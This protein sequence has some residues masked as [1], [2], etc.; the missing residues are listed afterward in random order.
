MKLPSEITFIENEEG[1][2][3]WRC[4][5]GHRHQP[6]AH[7]SGQAAPPE[8]GRYRAV[9]HVAELHWPLSWFIS[10]HEEPAMM[11]GLIYGMYDKTFFP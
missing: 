2:W 11:I 9:M 8:Y 3:T 6:V 5:C 4:K 1:G 7:P 10:E